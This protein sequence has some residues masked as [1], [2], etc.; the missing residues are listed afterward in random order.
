MP[1]YLHIHIFSCLLKK[2]PFRHKCLKFNVSKI[3][4]L[5]FPPTPSANHS[6]AH[7]RNQR[8]LLLFILP[9]CNS[10]LNKFHICLLLTISIAIT[11]SESPSYFT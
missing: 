4:V 8:H 7:P 5:I 11:P 9:T 6:L 1:M 3:K 2:S 10:I